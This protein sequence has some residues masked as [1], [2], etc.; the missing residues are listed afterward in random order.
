MA[1]SASYNVFSAGHG[2]IHLSGGRD[3][4]D[5]QSLR[6]NAIAIDRLLISNGLGGWTTVLSQSVGTPP[7]ASAP[8]STSHLS[9]GN[10]PVD[11]QLLR[12]HGLAIDRLLISNGLGGWTTVLSQSVGVND[13]GNLIGLADNDHP[14]YTLETIFKPFSASVQATTASLLEA[15]SSYSVVSASYMA[16]SASFNIISGSYI[17]VSASYN[18]LSS[19]YYPVSASYNIVSASYMAVSA[20][21]NTLSASYMAVS[22]SYNTFC[23]SHVTVHLSGGRDPID[24]QSLRANGIAIDRLLISNGLGGWTTVLSQSVGADGN[25]F[26]ST[27]FTAFASNSEPIT[28][29]TAGQMLLYA[30]NVAGRLIPKFKGPS[31][32]DCQVQPSFYGNGIS[33]ITPNTTTTFLFFNTVTF[34]AVGTVSTPALAA[35]S[36]RASTRR[37][38]VTS[39]ATTPSASELRVPNTICWRGDAA[40]LGGFFFVIRFGCSSAVA[41]QRLAVGLFGVTTAIATNQSPSAMVN[42]IFV[43]NDAA[44]ANLQIMHNDAAAA[45]TKVDLGA[46]FPVP[47]STNNAIYEV[48]FFCAANTATVGWRVSRIDTGVSTSGTIST[49]LVAN[50]TFLGSH[51]YINNN[52]TAAAVIL[53]FYRYY[54]ETD[55]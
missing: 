54:L 29:G 37:S 32:F 17:A 55:T 47:S 33:I 53:D 44:D 4:I 24:A 2:S 52:T 22:A 16:V 42:C 39:A 35:G 48:S 14:Q 12:G 46:S 5:A 8:H 34:T 45:C 9:G 25:Q 7:G 41:S 51:V 11:A 27:S 10:D 18:T 30:K 15:S 43:G 31:G 6:A 19:T 38:I 1:V 23:G 36:L 28:P 13:H 50:T 3:P 26:L 20:S 40:G 21:Y 49:D